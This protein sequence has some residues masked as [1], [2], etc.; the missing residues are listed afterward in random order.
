MVMVLCASTAIA[1]EEKASDAKAQEAQPFVQQ[2]SGGEWVE[3]EFGIRIDCSGGYALE[4]R[5]QAPIPIPWP[6]QEIEHYEET[7]SNNIKKINIRKFKKDAW[8]LEF[9]ASRLNN[10]DYAEAIYRYRVKRKNTIRPEDTDQFHFAKKPV[11]KLRAFLKPSPY[12]DSKN[13]QIIKIGKELFEENKD[14][15]DWDQVEAVYSWV[16]E[17]V[18]YKFDPNP[19]TCAEAL[20]SGHGD[21]EELSALFIATCRSRKIPAR[22]VWVP[23]HTYPEFYLEDATGK[24]HW[25]PCQI[26]GANHEFGEMSEDRP[27]MQ[28]GDRFKTIGGTKRYAE[29]GLSSEHATGLLKAD[30]LMRKVSNE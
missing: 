4:T 23:G 11:G 10:G 14:L 21:C 16:R 2:Y 25:F 1:Q 7:K 22:A 9:N 19:H 20:E 6:E 15:S 26:A 17:N 29:A 5:A 12:I 13:K 18:A 30:H 27:I 8:M 24:G 3:W 28:K